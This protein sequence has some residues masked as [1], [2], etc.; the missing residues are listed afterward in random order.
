M[1]LTNAEIG[2]EY[3][4]PTL[5]VWDSPEEIDFDKLPKKFVLK[6]NHDS[7]S[8]IVCHN[9]D[10]IN[11]EKII[12]KLKKSLKRNYFWTSREFNYKNIEKK[13]IAEEYISDNNSN[14][15]TDYKFFCFNGEPKFIQIDRN[16]FTN[17]TRNFYTI[18]WKYIDVEYG[19]KNDENINL[20]KPKFLEDMI[21]LAK[22]LSIG[23][24]HV[25]VDFYFSNGRIYF[26]ELTFHHGGGAMKIIPEEYDR[27]W[28]DMLILPQ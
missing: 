15:L 23:F 22:K 18:D 4:I 11:Y 5:G 1:N 20:D 10:N 14:E 7:G 19:C 28:G 3:I 13:I 25:R 12:K 26:G 6:C 27:I 8:V 17:H 2:K 9:K 24:A 21:S 16:R